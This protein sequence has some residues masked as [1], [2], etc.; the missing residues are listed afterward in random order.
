M[1]SGDGFARVQRDLAELLSQYRSVSLEVLEN[2][3]QHPQLE[4]MADA[5]T[6][7][8]VRVRRTCSHIYIYIT[9]NLM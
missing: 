8:K 6:K 7:K 9:V 1:H 4:Q 5:Y 2:M 3:M